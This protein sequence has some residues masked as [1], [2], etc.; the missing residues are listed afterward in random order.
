MRDRKKKISKEA[1]LILVLFGMVLLLGSGMF[2]MYRDMERQREKLNELG[3]SAVADFSVGWQGKTWCSYGD[4]ITGYNVWQPYVTD[5]FGF[6][7]H[8]LCGIGSATFVKSNLKWYANEDGT[9]NSQ[10]GL[11]NI[12]SPNCSLRR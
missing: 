8:Y 11:G 10:P 7:E 2:F 6:S 1:V 9:F 4:S 3:D 12:T 5:Y